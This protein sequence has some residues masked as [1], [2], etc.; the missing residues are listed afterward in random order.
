M[1]KHKSVKRKG[2]RL[3]PLAERFTFVGDAVATVDRKALRSAQ[4]EVVDTQ[5]GRDRNLK[6]WAKTGTAA[7]DDLRQLWLHEMR[8]VQRVMSYAG[9]REV[10]VDILEFVEDVEEFG[11][12]LEH[13]GQPLSAKLRTVPRQ[14]W[15]KNI[16]APRARVLLW[17]NLRRL[18]LAL[19]IVHA[20]G[21]V[22]GRIN[23]DAVM[24]E[25]AEVPDFQLTGFEWSLWLSADKAERAHA[26]RSLSP[27]QARPSRA[28][29]SLSRPHRR[30]LGH[31]AK[32]PATGDP[33][34]GVQT[35]WDSGLIRRLALRTVHGALHQ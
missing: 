17:Q 32:M 29:L 7:D 22:H 30:T 25:G 12:L 8:Q 19:G 20:Q 6:L 15:L 26:R 21:L 9:A 16:G 5:S 31:H 14:H 4:F 10:I 35:L 28:S 18:A 27:P 33:V 11:V 23:A 13:S 3:P 24:T 1:A 34:T 2:K